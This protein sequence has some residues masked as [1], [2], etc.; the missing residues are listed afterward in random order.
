[1][2]PPMRNVCPELTLGESQCTD[3][4][5]SISMAVI[6]CR[7][8]QN[9]IHD[10][11]CWKNVLLTFRFCSTA[12]SISCDR[13]PYAFL[14]WRQN[15]SAAYL[16]ALGSGTA[17]CSPIKMVRVSGAALQRSEGTVTAVDIA[18]PWI[19]ISCG[20]CRKGVLYPPARRSHV[21]PF[22]WHPSL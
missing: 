18:L 1:M 7:Q 15:S 22:A 11:D 13:F 3:S 9:R 6:P 4:L 20:D 12:R 2:Q 21:T 14:S 10:S 19:F 8:L 17:W 5:I 16:T